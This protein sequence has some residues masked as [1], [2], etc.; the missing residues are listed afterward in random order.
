MYKNKKYEVVRQPFPNGLINF[1][2]NYFL[3]QLDAVAYLLNE[4]KINSF[5]PLIGSFDDKQVPG[6]YSKYGDWVMDTLLQYARPLMEQKTGLKLV[7][8]FT[9]ARIYT[10]GNVLWRHSDRESCEVSTTI[11]LGG[12]PWPLY[13]DPTG[14]KS[15]IKSWYSKKGEECEVKPNAPTG[16]RVDLKP[17]D[18]MIYAGCDLEHWREKFE[19]KLCAQLFLHYNNVNGPLGITHFQDERPILGIPKYGQLRDPQQFHN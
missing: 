7:P 2:F 14:T 6:C 5:N 18:M 19:G 12:D 4:N 1:I 16:V 17:G 8:T 13:I 11:N 9:Y 10:Q 3:M 15:V